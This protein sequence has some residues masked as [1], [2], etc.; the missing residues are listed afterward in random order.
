MY[1][2]ELANRERVRSCLVLVAEI[3]EPALLASETNLIGQRVDEIL[4]THANSKHKEILIYGAVVSKVIE[5]VCEVTHP[6]TATSNAIDALLLRK[7]LM[8]KIHQTMRQI[9]NNI[10]SAK[11]SKWS[12]KYCKD[13][14]I[15]K[16]VIAAPT[17][18]SDKGKD[19]VGREQ[20][21]LMQE[22]V[23]CVPRFQEALQALNNLRVYGI[24]QQEAKSLALQHIDTLLTLERTDSLYNIMIAFL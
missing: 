24:Q 15:S 11:L 21:P 22:C 8:G 10:F 4:S 18:N 3:Y 13:D 12:E 2:N 1:M 19:D 6:L 14:T 5:I 7:D 23:S 17:V 20:L 9:G 16:A